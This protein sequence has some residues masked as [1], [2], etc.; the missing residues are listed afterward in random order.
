M[1]LIIW[2]ILGAIIIKH[3]NRKRKEYIE[4][5]KEEVK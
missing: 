3:T 5:L 4:F 2:F 1:E